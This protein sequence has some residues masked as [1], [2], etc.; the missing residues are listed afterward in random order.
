VKVELTGARPRI[1][2]AAEFPGGAKG[3]DVF[4]EAPD[5]LWIPLA[6][7]VSGSDGAVRTFEI[8]LTDGA[9]IGDLKGRE[10]RATLV[11]DSGQSEASFRLE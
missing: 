11:S 5:G 9:D 10:I 4:L 3:A 6:K 7:P 8:D 2:L 1:E